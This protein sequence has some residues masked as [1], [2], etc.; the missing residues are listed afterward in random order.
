MSDQSLENKNILV[1]RTNQLSLILDDTVL[2]KFEIKVV[3]KDVSE[4]DEFIH[5][6]DKPSILFWDI[7]NCTWDTHAVSTWFKLD[8]Q[9]VTIKE[10][11]LDKISLDTISLRP[12][13]EYMLRWANKEGIRVIFVTNNFKTIKIILWKVL[14][15]SNINVDGWTLLGVEDYEELN[16]DDNLLYWNRE[17]LDI[18]QFSK[19]RLIE[20]YSQQDEDLKDILGKC[21]FCDDRGGNCRN[22][23]KLMLAL[24]YPIS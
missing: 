9:I 4:Y 13:S 7:D 10:D 1:R 17:T 14:K 24:H 16:K 23:A 3:P 20:R 5:N 18:Y 12:F 6:M 22:V 8:Q 15:E 2:T 11:I 21:L 19:S